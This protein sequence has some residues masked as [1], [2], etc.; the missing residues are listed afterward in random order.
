MQNN[1]RSNGFDGVSQRV[2]ISGTIN[3]TESINLALTIKPTDEM[4]QRMSDRDGIDLSEFQNI[5]SVS[6][7]QLV[8]YEDVADDGLT[9]DDLIVSTF[10][11]SSDN[12]QD[13]SI[14]ENNEETTYS[15]ISNDASFEMIIEINSTDNVPHQWKWSLIMKYNYVSDSSKLAVLHDITIGRGNL[16]REQFANASTHPDAFNKR[17]LSRSHPQLPMFFRWDSSAFSNNLEIEVETTKYNNSLSLSFLQ[18][19]TITYDPSIGTN[20]ES[21]VSIDFDIIEIFNEETIN[22][23][24]DQ[25]SSPTR[26]GLVLAIIFISTIAIVTLIKKNR[27]K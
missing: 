23:F 16:I 5:I 15:I 26:R 2:N 14:N 27:S 20:L 21:I 12:L 3:I 8:E 4:L 13:I 25:I 6:L 17:E 11:L 24:I 9:D 1:R 19:E 7:T 22:E 18:G 10:N